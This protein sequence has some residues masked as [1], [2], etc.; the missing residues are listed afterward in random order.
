[1]IPQHVPRRRVAL[2]SD[3]NQGEVKSI[4]ITLSASPGTVTSLALPDTAQGVKIFP[5]SQPIRFAFNE[6]PAPV[7]QS[8]LTS[9]P[10][11]ELKTGG[12]AKADTWEIRLLEAGSG[13]TLRLS[14]IA[15][16]VIVDVEVW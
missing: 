7:G 13:R 4:E 14:S 15:A 8:G 1:M 6:D 11:T 16:S 12:I 2:Q 9:I 5:R 3:L 10:I